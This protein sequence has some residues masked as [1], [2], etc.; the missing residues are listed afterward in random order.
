M[1]RSGKKAGRCTFSI[2]QDVTPTC[3]KGGK[4]KEEKKTFVP[5]SGGVLP[6][7]PQ[8]MEHR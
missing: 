2:V 8:P 6:A 1:K 7:G 3:E 4:K 5:S